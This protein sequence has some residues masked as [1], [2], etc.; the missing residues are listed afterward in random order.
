MRAQGSVSA[1]AMSTRPR[2]G[3]RPRSLLAALQGPTAF[4]DGPGGTQCPDS[5]IDAIAGYLRESNA[6]LGGPFGNSRR[7]D[8]LVAQARADRGV[9]PRLRSGRDDL[10][11]EHDDAQ[12]RA[13]AR[14]RANA[15]APGTRSSSRGSTTTANV[16]PWLE[17]AHDLD[18]TVRFVDI[19]RR[20]DARPRRPRA[21]ADRAERAS[22]RSRSRRTPSARSPTPAAIVELAHDAGALAWADAVHYAP[23]G[24]DRRRRARRRRARLLAVQVLRPAPRA[25]VRPRRARRL[26]A[27]VQGAAARTSRFETG[28]LAHELLAGFVAAVDYIDSIGWPAIQAHERALGERFLAGLPDRCT[29]HGLPAMDGRVPTFAFTVDGIAPRAVAGSARRARHR[30]LGRQLLRGRGDEA[31]RP[32]RRRRRA[33]RLRPLQHRGG[34]RP[35]PHRPGGAV[36]TDVVELLR[37]L[38]PLRHDEPA[39]ERGARASRTCSGSS[40]RPASSRAS[41]R[42]DDARPNLV[43]RVQGA[44]RRRRCSSTGTSTSSPPRARSGRTRPSRASSSTAGSGAAARST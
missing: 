38:H 2:R 25:R 43:A 20:H 35:A 22:S 42:R 24:A 12:L 33:R 18:L 41:S 5:V 34:G 15:A 16:S 40:T 4:F 7:S 21:A 1:V 36:V 19:A 44:A 23:H 29:L 9:L 3:R 31:A 6:N 8:A 32:R 26:V 13:L 37:D 39:G 10:R 28:T 11:G 27:D 17:L 30:R 14:R